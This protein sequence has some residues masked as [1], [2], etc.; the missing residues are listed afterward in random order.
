MSR[1]LDIYQ[2]SQDAE[3][4]N[5]LEASCWLAVVPFSQDA[6]VDVLAR[7]IGVEGNVSSPSEFTDD[8]IVKALQERIS[9]V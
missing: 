6:V 9:G 8:Q 3:F 1:L 7:L 4:R 2:F 5:R